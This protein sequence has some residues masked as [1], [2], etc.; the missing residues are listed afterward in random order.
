M[1]WIDVLI[2]GIVQ[3]LAEYLPISSSGHIEI[4]RQI[5]GLDL[6]GEDALQL[7][8]V[9]HVATVLSTIVVLWKQFMPFAARF[10]PFA[11]MTTH[12]MCGKY[13]FH[14]CRWVSSASFSNRR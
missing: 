12:A 5:L 3:G 11:T 2:L 6:P 10:S 14:V 1:D 9:L 4:F 8:V 13:C 7:N